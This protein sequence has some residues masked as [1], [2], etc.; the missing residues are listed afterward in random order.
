[1]SKRDF[2]NNLINKLE[3]NDTLDRQNYNDHKEQISDIYDV[4]DE[5][6]EDFMIIQGQIIQ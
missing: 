6:L 1:M 3:D 2:I 4:I 5:Y